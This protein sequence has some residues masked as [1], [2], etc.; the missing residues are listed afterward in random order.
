[1]RIADLRQY[2][3]ERPGCAV[4]RSSLAR[5]RAFREQQLLD[6]QGK[7]AVSR[8]YARAS[9]SPVGTGASAA[10]AGPGRALSKIAKCKDGSGGMTSLSPR[11]LRPRPAWHGATAPGAAC[12][13]RGRGRGSIGSLRWGHDARHRGS[14]WRCE[15]SKLARRRG[16]GGRHEQLSTRLSH[17]IGC[18]QILKADVPVK[19]WN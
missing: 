16:F 12:S 11:I 6:D 8:F 15:G 19:V 4:S 13:C 5:Q 14:R 17:I 3:G 18:R 10:A 1:V 9:V 7:P 2:R